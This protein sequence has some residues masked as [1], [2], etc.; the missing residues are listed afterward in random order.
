MQQQSAVGSSVSGG[1]NPFIPLQAARKSTKGK[2]IQSTPSNDTSQPNVK[3]QV[4][5]EVTA[6]QKKDASKVE[7]DLPVTKADSGNMKP[8]KSSRKSRL[9]IN[10]EK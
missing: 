10:F 8:A 1:A 4:V 9:A 6:D 5:Q 3:T 7:T 2:N